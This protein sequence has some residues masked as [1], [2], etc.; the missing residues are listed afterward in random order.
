MSTIIGLTGRRGVGKSTIVN[1]L[2][3]HRG[4]VSA[5]SFNPGKAAC[6]GYFEHLGAHAET[7]REMTDGALRNMPASILPMDPATPGKHHTPRDFME[8][9]GRFMAQDLGLDWT[10]GREIERLRESRPH[11]IV[12]DSVAYEAS[13]I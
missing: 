13:F 6:R 12:I 9:M 7:A 10:I 2:V 11:S 8:K 5:H 1:H 3:E 4:F